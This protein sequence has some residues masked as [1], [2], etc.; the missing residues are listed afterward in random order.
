MIEK[1]ADKPS[2]LEVPYL[3]RNPVHQGERYTVPIREARMVV[4]CGFLR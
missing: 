3:Q 4:S 2:T 1:N